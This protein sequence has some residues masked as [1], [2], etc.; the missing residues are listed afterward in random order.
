MWY[1]TWRGGGFFFLSWRHPFKSTRT[2]EMKKKVEKKRKKIYVGRLEYWHC[3]WCCRCAFSRN[4]SLG[5]ESGSRREYLWR[6]GRF[7]SGGRSHQMWQSWRLVLSKHTDWGPI[8]SATLVGV[9]GGRYFK[10]LQRALAGGRGRRRGVIERTS[11]STRVIRAC[12]Y[13][14]MVIWKASIVFR[15]TGTVF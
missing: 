9:E 6:I 1:S 8:I 10:G 14:S 12:R 4:R 7:W 5:W 13:S 15:L 11:S 3:T 2:K